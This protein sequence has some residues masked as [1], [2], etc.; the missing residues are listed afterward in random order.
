M[1]LREVSAWWSFQHLAKSSMFRSN[2][3]TRGHHSPHLPTQPFS[4]PSPQTSR[5]WTLGQHARDCAKVMTCP[6]T[7][8]SSPCPSSSWPIRSHI[9]LDPPLCG[10]HH[11]IWPWWRTWFWSVSGYSR[12]IRP[13]F[14]S[15]RHSRSSPD[16]VCL[17]LPVNCDGSVN[18]SPFPQSLVLQPSAS[19]NFLH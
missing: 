12:H 18:V 15:T 10:P 19:L 1:W 9:R 3:V 17:F 7:F 8:S 5:Q 4:P 13:L 11:I 2:T 16:S 6:V 14:T